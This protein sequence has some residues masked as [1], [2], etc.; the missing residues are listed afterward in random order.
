LTHSPLSAPGEEEKLGLCRQPRW[1][2]GAGGGMYFLNHYL[3]ALQ[4][5]PSVPCVAA[6]ILHEDE[7]A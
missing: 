7:I 2:G 5:D 1:G 3:G 4:R 6:E